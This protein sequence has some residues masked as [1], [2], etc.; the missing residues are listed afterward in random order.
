MDL[1]LFIV[2]LAAGLF[3]GYQAGVWHGIAR[4]GNQE[5][6]DRLSKMRKR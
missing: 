1:S 2:G 5:R 6:K 4:L 3:L